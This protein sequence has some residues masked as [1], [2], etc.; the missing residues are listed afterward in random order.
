MLP[1]QI[2]L[3]E[4]IPTPPPAVMYRGWRVLHKVEGGWPNTPAGMPEVMPPEVVQAVEMTMWIQ[5]MSYDLM[6]KVNTAITTALW[7]KIHSYDR[8]FNNF[9]QN[10]Y[11]G[12]IVHADF[13]NGKDVNA[14]L[15]RYDKAQRVCGGS[16]VTGDAVSDKLV[17]RS[18]VHGIDPDGPMPEINTIIA[19]HWF[20]YAVSIGT[21]NEGAIS[22]FPQGKGGPVLIPLIFRGTITFPLK[23]FERWESDSLPDPLRIYK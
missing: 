18:G 21:T 6:R 14:S 23:Y 3:G 16:F 9:P 12:G 5:V 22:H 2:R 10:G 20:I 15:P 19:K 17:M 13:I 1:V 4:T 11:D 7:R 8:A